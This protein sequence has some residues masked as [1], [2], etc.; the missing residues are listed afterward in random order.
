[1][2]VEAANVTG[3]NSCSMTSVFHFKQVAWEKQS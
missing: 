2:E 3:K 1:M